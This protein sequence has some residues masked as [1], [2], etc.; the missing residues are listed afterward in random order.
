[1]EA[2]FDGKIYP[3]EMIAERQRDLAVSITALR[4]MQEHHG[5]P[6]F[7][8]KCVSPT[9]EAKWYQKAEAVIPPVK[10]VPDRRG[11]PTESDPDRPYCKPDQSCC[12]FCCGN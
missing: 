7:S 1:M 6:Y 3:H 2:E 9:E 5:N 12:D 4:M 11:G 8:F 10:G